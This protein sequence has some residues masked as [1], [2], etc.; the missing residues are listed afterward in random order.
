MSKV[1]HTQ[2]VRKAKRKP[3]GTI[4]KSTANVNNN[5]QNVEAW[6]KSSSKAV[7]YFPYAQ[8]PSAK[9]FLSNLSHYSNSS[10]GTG[11]LDIDHEETK[12]LLSSG[13][14]AELGTLAREQSHLHGEQDSS[15]KKN[16]L[17]GSLIGD[18]GDEELSDLSSSD[19]SN[20]DV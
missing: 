8:K 10:G 7:E 2:Q 9:T 12:R 13:F 3:L 19:E 16:G 4:S 20:D 1:K 14:D 5:I 17:L 11:P 15:K 6:P 18:M